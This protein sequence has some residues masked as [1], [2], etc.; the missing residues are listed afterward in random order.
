MSADEI[1]QRNELTTLLLRH[2]YNVFLPVYDHGIDLIAY[3]E[4]RRQPL[5]HAFLPP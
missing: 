2:G 5:Y 1:I 4:C 3:R